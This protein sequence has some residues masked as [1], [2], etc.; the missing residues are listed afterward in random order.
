MARGYPDFFGISI[1]PKYGTTYRATGVAVVTASDRTDIITVTGKGILFGGTIDAY[2]GGNQQNSDI[3]LYIDGNL[4]LNYSWVG[5]KTYNYSMVA[6]K[7]YELTMF[8]NNGGY[9]G[10]Y[11]NFDM[12][13]EKSFTLTYNELAGNTPTV[14]A[15]LTYANVT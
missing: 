6:I 3:Y 15:K 11:L 5:L 4:V 1:I 8:D 10:A 13:F 9:Y 2:N 7:G 12:P 14:S